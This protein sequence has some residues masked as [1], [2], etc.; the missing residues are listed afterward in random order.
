[1]SKR[2][3]GIDTQWGNLVY[4]QRPADDADTFA[5]NWDRIFGKKDKRSEEEIK[6]SEITS[7]QEQN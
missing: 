6:E 1:M 5:N 7:E 2:I 4:V 3:H